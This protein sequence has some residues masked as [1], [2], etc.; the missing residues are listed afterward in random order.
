MFVDTFPDFLTIFPDFNV[1]LVNVDL[2]KSQL[3]HGL[4]PPLNLYVLIFEL[5]NLMFNKLN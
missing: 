4:Y 5:D 3:S 2:V 1:K